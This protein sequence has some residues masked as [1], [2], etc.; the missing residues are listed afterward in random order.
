MEFLFYSLAY[1]SV[2]CVCACLP[3]LTDVLLAYNIA[4]VCVHW[5]MFY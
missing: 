5:P 1:N 2:V 3:P 4:C